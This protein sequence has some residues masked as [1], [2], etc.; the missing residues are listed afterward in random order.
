[1]AS[2]C[3]M[4]VCAIYLHRQLDAR[5]GWDLPTADASI[6]TLFSRFPIFVVVVVMDQSTTTRFALYSLHTPFFFC[7]FLDV[8]I[9]DDGHRSNCR[10]MSIP[11]HTHRCYTA[12]LFVYLCRYIYCPVIFLD[13]VIFFCCV[14]VRVSRR[15]HGV[16]S[17]PRHWPDVFY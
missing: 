4:Q 8:S 15:R 14:C 10:R 3:S 17:L 6:A 2:S 16:A 1:M 12:S 7:S 11:V 9:V 5:R 13:L